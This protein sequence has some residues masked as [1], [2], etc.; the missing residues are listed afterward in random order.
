MSRLIVQAKRYFV[1]PREFDALH[2]TT[3]HATPLFTQLFLF[4]VYSRS[5]TRDISWSRLELF[6][7]RLTEDKQAAVYCTRP[8]SIAFAWDILRGRF[9]YSTCARR[10]PHSISLVSYDETEIKSD[11]WYP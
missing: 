3:R 10:A 2:D 5:R 6:Y 9:I 7:E 1:K 4:L 8:R 11:R